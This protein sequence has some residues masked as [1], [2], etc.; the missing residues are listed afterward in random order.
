MHRPTKWHRLRSSIPCLPPWKDA[1]PPLFGGDR[2][3]PTSPIS[4]IPKNGR[5]K[6]CGKTGRPW[7]LN[8]SHQKGGQ[9]RDRRRNHLTSGDLHQNGGFLE[10]LRKGLDGCV[11]L[12]ISALDY[13]RFMSRRPTPLPSSPSRIACGPPFSPLFVGNFF[14]AH[15]KTLIPCSPG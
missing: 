12:W 8:V 5:L 10:A 13:A 6:R 7:K 4:P 14:P 15:G 9:S 1:R 3:P 11:H 2:P